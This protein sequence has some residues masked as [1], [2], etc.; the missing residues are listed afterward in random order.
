MEMRECPFCGKSVLARITQCTYCR[1]PLLP[2]PRPK[3][4]PG[5]PGDTQIRRG[6]LY[7]LTAAVIGY[8]AGGYSILKVPIAVLPAV[9]NY[10]SPLLFL[11]GLGLAVHGYYLQHKAVRRNSA[12]SCSNL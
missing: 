8:F 7:M 9:S 2:A 6:L 3:S 5:A 4:T 12:S 11:S 1:E 10:L